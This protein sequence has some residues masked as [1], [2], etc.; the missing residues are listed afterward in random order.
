MRIWKIAAIAACLTGLPVA[1]ATADAMDDD[2]TLTKDAPY[3]TA[4]LSL[5]IRGWRA[6][7]EGSNTADQR[8]FGRPEICAAYPET[9]QCSGTGVGACQFLFS[10]EDRK[11]LAV[12]TEG[13]SLDGLSVSGWKLSGP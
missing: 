4:R 8:C 10:N 7:P 2:V 1:F 3:E 11:V 12:T 5:F 13:E 9:N 6:A